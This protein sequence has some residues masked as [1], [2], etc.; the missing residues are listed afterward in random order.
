MNRTCS[1]KMA[2][3]SLCF[4]VSLVIL[5]VSIL[6]CAPMSAY[7]MEYAV[8]GM[9][10]APPPSSDEP[11][12]TLTDLVTPFQSLTPE[13]EVWVAPYGDDL[14]AGTLFE[15]KHTIAGALKIATPGTAIMVKA[16]S[17]EE[18]VDITA[19]AGTQGK[20]IW[21][22][23]A[24]GKGAAGIAPLELTRAALRIVASRNIIIEGMKI[25]GGIAIDQDAAGNPSE[26]VIL[27][28]NLI[29]QCFSS[30]VSAQLVRNLY[31]IS[32]DI[33]A[34]MN[35]EGV[36]LVA[37]A[38]GAVADNYVH[39]IHINTALSDGIN[40]HGDSHDLLIANNYVEHVDGYGLII[41]GLNQSV[42]S[43]SLAGTKGALRINDCVNC[44][45]E[46]NDLIYSGSTA[47]VSVKTSSNV[48][49]INNCV[50]QS[51]WLQIEAGADAGLVQ[52]NNTAT[53][54]R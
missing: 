5:F 15:P 14:A 13:R 45:L 48:K 1:D 24:D 18:F 10:L 36:N 46:R 19:I 20:P 25:R 49:F 29:Y 27:K 28:N 38:F 52:Q 12:R 53:S 3:D 6:G 22:R 11:G 23:S 4:N 2:S 37:T 21:L 9:S 54:C 30:G 17:Y 39:D 50:H 16:G 47:G 32:N 26:T 7:K 33:S 31:I 51:P 34:C 40:V 42:V 8:S 43:N 41:E 35:G 44:T